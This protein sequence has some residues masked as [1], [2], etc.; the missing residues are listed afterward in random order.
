[1]E[2][3]EFDLK[4]AKVSE[5]FKFR[6]ENWR[7]T[8]DSIKSKVKSK[9]LLVERQDMVKGDRQRSVERISKKH[10]FQVDPCSEARVTHTN[11]G[12]YIRESGSSFIVTNHGKNNYTNLWATETAHGIG[13]DYLPKARPTTSSQFTSV[14]K[15][16]NSSLY[17]NRLSHD[18]TGSSDIVGPMIPQVAKFKG[19]SG[20]PY[21][22][23]GEDCDSS[24]KRRIQS[25]LGHRAYH[26]NMKYISNFQIPQVKGRSR[27]SQMQ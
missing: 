19:P 21:I 23:T 11:F 2:E 3:E 7:S 12:C 4:R 22:S 26:S 24:P 10:R 20:R 17:L 25:V 8:I 6:K 18:H 16:L 9:I 5:R 15:N 13:T 14:S 1:M 27:M